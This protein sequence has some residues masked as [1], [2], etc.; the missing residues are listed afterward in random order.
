[1]ESSSHWRLKGYKYQVCDASYSI[2]GYIRGEI[3]IP[4]SAP[5]WIGVSA[6]RTLGSEEPECWERAEF[7]PNAGLLRPRSNAYHMYEASPHVVDIIW[8]F[9]TERVSDFTSFPDSVA[10]KWYD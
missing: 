7:S 1:M 6:C 5:N 3:L 9:E 4:F 2:K 8:V 10:C